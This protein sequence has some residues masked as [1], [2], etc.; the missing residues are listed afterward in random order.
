MLNNPRELA[1]SIKLRNKISAIDQK[2]LEE[3]QKELEDT[4]TLFGSKLKDWDRTKVLT[5][6]WGKCGDVCKIVLEELKKLNLTGFDDLKTCSNKGTYYY[7]HDK[8]NNIIVD[9]TYKQFLYRAIF[10]PETGNFKDDFSNKEE[11]II[12]NAPN[13]FMGSPDELLVA[14]K[15]MGEK[16]GPDLGTKLLTALSKELLDNYGKI[17]SLDVEHTLL[18]KEQVYNGSPA[19]LS[20]TKNTNDNIHKQ[21]ITTEQTGDQW[22]ADEDIDRELGKYQANNNKVMLIPAASTDIIQGRVTLSKI[23]QESFLAASVSRNITEYTI[24]PINFNNNHWACL[25]IKQ[26]P[27]QRSA[28]DV[29]FFDS[30]GS[31]DAKLELVHTALKGSG[32]YTNAVLHDL[33]NS[34]PNQKDGYTCGTWLIESAQTI[35]SALQNGKDPKDAVQN[36][37]QSQVTEKHKQIVNSRLP[38][39]TNKE[40]SDASD[41]P[42]PTLPQSDSDHNAG[43][44]SGANTTS[45]TDG[46]TKPDAKKK[47]E[48]PSGTETQKSQDK[49]NTQKEQKKQNLQESF[50]LTPDYIK[51]TNENINKRQITTEQ[52]G[53]QW[54]ADEDIDRELGKYQANN[55][56]VTLIPAAGTNITQGRVTLSEIIRDSFLAASVS[57][58]ITEYT[59]C[60][61][62]FNNN[63]WACLVIKQN[64]DQRSAPNV[65]FFDSLGSTDAKFELVHT[66]LKGSGVYTK[67]V[68]HDLSK[69]GPMQKDGY[70]A[71]TWSIESAQT[72]VN[73]LQNKNDPKFAV[74]N[75]DQGQITTKHDSIISRRPSITQEKGS[76]SSN[77]HSSQGE[78]KNQHAQAPSPL[79]PNPTKK[80][81]ENTRFCL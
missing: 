15:N 31:T 79:M 10:D 12:K 41:Q 28:P 19:I 13:I 33:S 46:S 61:I 25:V 4:E 77:N 64:P 35:V 68:L 80:T 76:T 78:Q 11:E 37:E 62:N 43:V 65:Y 67:A 74:Q 40:K 22:L 30:L 3:L 36:L 54:L 18:G 14:F 8:A 47:D 7:L 58:N 66:A 59:I 39:L 75:L 69:A 26:N 51:R 45:S 34:E 70:T 50:P 53:D 63:H 17:F 16:L 48:Q 60:P 72:I 81:N 6:R 29:Y 27:D 32:V 42:N 23:I 20:H 38:K 44:S 49:S 56:K 21:Q 1:Q 24:C 57:R 9:P 55:N 2:V 71:G 52:T 73:A 5:C